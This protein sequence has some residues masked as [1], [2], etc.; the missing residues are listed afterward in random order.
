MSLF[1]RGKKKNI[2]RMSDCVKTV[3]LDMS[4]KP[5]NIQAGFRF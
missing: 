5:I 4:K 3:T 2:Q 1:L